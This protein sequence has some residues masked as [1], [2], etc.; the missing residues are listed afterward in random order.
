MIMKIPKQIK[1]IGL[2][3]DIHFGKKNNSRIHNQD[4]LDYVDW[5]C[6][7][8]KKDKKITHLA[9]LG[10]WFENRSSINIETLEYSYRALKKL[11]DLGLPIFFIVGNHDLHRRTTR[12]IHSVNMFNEFQNIQVIDKPTEIDGVLFCPFIFEHEY[13]SLMKH[14][15]CTFWAGHFEFR[16]FLIT[17]YNT[18]ME[19]GPDHTQF[20]GPK[21]IFSGHFHKK[22]RQDNVLYIS[23]TFPMDYGDAGDND[24]GMTTYEVE[25]DKVDFYRWEDCPK[26]MNVKL[27]QIL[28]G[29][30]TIP[31]KTHVQCLVDID[32]D[33]TDGQELKV[34]LM[35]TYGLR[36]FTLKE[37]KIEKQELLEDGVVDELDESVFT[38][39]DELVIG[40]L[41]TIKEDAAKIDGKMLVEIYKSLKV[42][43]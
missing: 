26:Y 21:Q 24:R 31:P 38:G 23:N 19:R 9:F 22:Q 4:C 41:E 36:E 29:D 25:L 43:G 32:I 40:L 2:F 16:N 12:E 35:E 37:N 6:S 3:T 7:N 20:A 11:N 34:T 5:F 17:G 13:A 15:D 27:S 33:Y 42:V 14:L 30:L 1:K 39:T 10:D 8:I 28:S 18:K